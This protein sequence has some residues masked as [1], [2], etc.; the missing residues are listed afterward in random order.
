M[1]LV[2]LTV[3][4]PVGRGGTDLSELGVR[5][6]TTCTV[7]EVAV[8]DQSALYGLLQR[9]SALG[10]ELRELRTVPTGA[11]AD[12]E[13][14]V[15]GPVG[16]V[17]RAMLRGVGRA[18]PAEVSSYRL[19]EADLAAVLAV[20]DQ[21]AR[22]P[23]PGDDGFTASAHGGASDES[24]AIEGP[25]DRTGTGGREMDRTID[26]MGPVDYI[27]VEFPQNRLDGEAL[28]LLVDLV[29]RGVIRV[30]DLA[31]VQKDAEGRVAG[32]ELQDLDV[33]G[34]FDLAVFD[35]ASSGILDEEDLQEAGAALEPGSA[36][37]VLVYENSW[38]APF[39]AALRRGG[40][41][42]VASG[43]IP[44]QSL[45]AALDAAESR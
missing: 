8:R 13:V 26:E 40:G 10:L 24:S 14:V 6:T 36:A 12:V 4:G 41:M 44:V 39:A 1:S 33:D 35:G 27:V 3:V 29:D 16:A 37:G 25:G 2:E 32:M 22:S 34:D 23:A 7:L 45:V 15:H 20:A 18:E 17:V 11:W 43:R 42:L 5:R 9:L 19:R 28:P 21:A 31:F 38:A 30:L